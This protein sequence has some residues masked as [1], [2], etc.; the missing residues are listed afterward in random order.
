MSGIAELFA[1]RGTR[2]G[3]LLLSSFSSFTLWSFLIQD[4]HSPH[5]TVT[6][7][8]KPWILTDGPVVDPPVE[9]DYDPNM[10]VI[11]CTGECLM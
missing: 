1:R 5:F 3:S 7:S 6:Y 8:G 4:T 2:E 11:L 9:F 10:S